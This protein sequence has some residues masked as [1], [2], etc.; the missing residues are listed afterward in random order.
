MEPSSSVDVFIVEDLSQQRLPARSLAAVLR[1][2]GFR[3]RLVDLNDGAEAIVALAKR[4]TPRLIISSI[5]FADRVDEYL[6][7]M[8]ALHNAGVCVHLTMVGP[9][10]AFAFAELLNACPALDSILR[11]EA[12]SSVAQL[13]TVIASEAK[14]SPTRDLEIASSHR[15]L[16]A[17]TDYSAVPGLAFR[18]PAICA[19]PL[20]KPVAD[21][22]DLPFPARDDGITAY[23]GYGF[24]TI[25]SS[26]G[27]YHTCAF[28]LPSAFYREQGVRYRLRSIANLVDEI[29]SL[30]HQ[31]VRLFLFDDEQFFPPGQARAERVAT[32][33][34]ELGRRNLQI[35]FT[36][37]CRADDVEESLFR[38]LKEMGLLR[39]YI[40][41]ESGCQ[42]TLNLL[43]KRVTAQ[44]NAE[45]LALLDA[46]GIVADF[47][48][49]LFHPWSTLQSVQTEIAFLQRV[50]S[51]HSTAFDLREVGIYP[52]TLLA[53]RVRA[54]G[55]IRGDAWQ[56]QY[57]IADPRV[58]LLR[59]L[60]RF[61]FSPPGAYAS[62][63]DMLTRAWYTLLLTRRFC[64]S[65]SDADRA[66]ELKEI[67]MGVNGE[68][69]NVWQEMLAFADDG[70]IYDA[71]Q[72]NKRAG[73]W[74]GRINAMCARVGKSLG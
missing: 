11:G 1:C 2:A 54:E 59:R 65:S 44:Q 4:A 68:E 24:T 71:N 72:V 26:R 30:C 17:M 51:C 48:C 67:A 35:A 15:T 49:L 40:G 13:A 39:V 5:I 18:S 62:V 61:V 53:R 25:E 60:C 14:Q 23:L 33:A 46:L 31:G 16:L 47:Q 22:D 37:K 12:E 9:L 73:A 70:D 3:V 36:I 7:L 8:T 63:Q 52:G 21:L 41:V 43:G 74:A 56:M 42:T 10:P 55:R 34:D 66:R 45:A 19:N 29:K 58:E 28:C 6:A 32:L 27:C 50:V 20:P 64:P 69:L 57:T 38:R